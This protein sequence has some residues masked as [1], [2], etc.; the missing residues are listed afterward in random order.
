M[1]ASEKIRTRKRL[2]SLFDFIENRIKLMVTMPINPVIKSIK[3]S[4][5]IK[6]IARIYDEHLMVFKPIFKL[7]AKC[8]L[9]FNYLKIFL[10]FIY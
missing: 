8:H 5:K 3:F 9:G 10:I 6:F 4:N 1:L 2:T 7:L